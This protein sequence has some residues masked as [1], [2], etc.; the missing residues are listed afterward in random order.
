MRR[1]V[2][3]PLS[4]GMTRIHEHEVRRDLLYQ[5]ER[6]L[7]I[8]GDQHGEARMVERVGEKAERLGR[9]IHDQNRVA[10]YVGAWVKLC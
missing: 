10:A 8:G 2:S 5:T 4:P 7:A 3:K 6:T 9:V 1:Q